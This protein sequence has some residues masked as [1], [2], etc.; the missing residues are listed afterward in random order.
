MNFDAAVDVR[1]FNLKL[2]WAPRAT[3]LHD[4]FI[5]ALSFFIKIWEKISDFIAASAVLF[6]SDAYNMLE[7][8][9]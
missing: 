3:S 8:L 2:N 6:K 4:L 5:M 1:S 9:R 7:L